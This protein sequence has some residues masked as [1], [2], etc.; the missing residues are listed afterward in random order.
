MERQLVPTAAGHVHLRLAGD[1]SARP[2][3]LL[4]HQSPSSG[5]MWIPVMELLAPDV[6]TCAI[7]L[8]GYGESDPP[9]GQLTLEQ[10]A[11]LLVEAVETA[12]DGPLVVVGHHTGAVVA[13]EIAARRPDLVRGVMLSGYP[14]Y[15]EWRT[16]L[17]RLGPVLRPAAVSPDGAELL[18][19]WRYVTGPLEDD[20]DP[21]VGLTIM[22][23]R[24]RAGREWFTAYVQLLGADLDQIL[25]DAATAAPVRPTTILTAERDPLRPYAE[26]VAAR[27]GVTPTMV[28]GTSWVTYEHPDR[29]AGPIVELLAR[30]RD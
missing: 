30:V 26:A 23:D 13:A 16:K 28:P 1:T 12:T 9:S 10:H 14:L 19:I 25:D 29:V 17:A 22:T 11:A 21:E 3:V 27:F 18:E 6:R 8:L 5:R 7:D 2:T 20:T 24:L 15:P 4:V